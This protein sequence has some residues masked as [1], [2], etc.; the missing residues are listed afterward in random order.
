MNFENIDLKRL[1]LHSI[2]VGVIA[3]LTAHQNGANTT[4]AVITGLTALLGTG[5]AFRVP[6]KK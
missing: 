2:V 6:P 4:G 5:N 1:G 3:G